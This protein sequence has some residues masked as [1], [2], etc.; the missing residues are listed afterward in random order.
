MDTDE[1][2]FWGRGRGRNWSRGFLTA[3]FADFTDSWFGA[4][5]IAEVTEKPKI[6]WGR[7]A[8]AETGPADFA[9]YTDE[10]FGWNSSASAPIRVIRGQN[11]S[12]LKSV[13][14]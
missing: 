6:L 14:Q 5:E 12:P 11:N 3:D 4:T 13:S 1:H 7:E 2:G 8:V 10:I 9:D